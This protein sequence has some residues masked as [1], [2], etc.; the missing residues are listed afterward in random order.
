MNKVGMLSLVGLISL[1]AP[2]NA[3]TLWENTRAGMTREEL[4][5]VQPEVVSGEGYTCVFRI[6]EKVIA[7]YPMEVCFTYFH[8]GNALSAVTLHQK[9]SAA[10]FPDLKA[11]LT[12]K[13]GDPKSEKCNRLT[14]SCKVEWLHEKLSISLSRFGLSETYI[15]YQAIDDSGL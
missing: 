8:N 10:A 5:K 15:T 1:A 7:G 14:D 12:S 6:P 13:Y 2:L 4:K 9:K 11:A 3:Q